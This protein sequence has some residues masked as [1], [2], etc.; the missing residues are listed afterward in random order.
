[1]CMSISYFASSSLVSLL[2]KKISPGLT[3]HPCRKAI[4]DKDVPFIE[5]LPLSL[6]PIVS[7]QSSAS[8][9]KACMEQM[10]SVMGCLSKFDQNEVSFTSTIVLVFLWFLSPSSCFLGTFFLVTIFPSLQAMCEK[11]IGAFNKCYT[12]FKANASKAK[13][14]RESGVLPLGQYAKMSGVK[15]HR[16]SS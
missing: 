2:L 4:Q 1:M 12:G 6:K 3:I 10:M 5:R 16:T 8:K 7:N 13:A 11:E 9:E 14:F 15:S